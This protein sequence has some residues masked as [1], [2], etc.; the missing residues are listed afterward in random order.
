[1]G[2]IAVGGPLSMVGSMR[3]MAGPSPDT[4][5]VLVALSLHNRGLTFR[6]DGNEF[7]AEYR[8]ELAFRRGTE[9]IRQV[10]RD[11][12]IR[13]SSFRETL[14]TEESVIF[15]Q[16]VPVRAGDY[17]V[18]VV[19]R[20]RNGPNSARSQ[21]TL[22][23]PGL[24]PPAVSAAVAVYEATPRT[25]LAAPPTLIANPRNAVAYGKDS[26]KFYIE[27]YG[28]PAGSIL[29]VEATDPG[30]RTVFQDTL[31]PDAA[32]AVDGRVIVVPPGR[33][34]IGRHELRVTT[35]SGG[36]LA[37]VPFLVAFSDLWAIANFEDMISLL[38]YLPPADT[39]RTLSS[40]SPEERA[41]GWQAFWRAS[42]PNP[43]TPENEALDR[44]FAR[45]QLANE[46]FRDEGVP[47]WL[48]ERGEVFIT[49]G[50]PTNIIDQNPE[51]QG[52]GRV[53]YWTYDEYR[54]QLAFVDETGF[55]RMRLT[56]RSRAEYLVVVNRLRRQ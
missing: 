7:A 23:V 9:M 25:T 55:G 22:G 27:A 26:V 34:S 32:R 38:R 45:V 29:T 54:L 53:M 12:R 14:R 33:F 37:T 18:D 3:L 24:A 41:A 28:L 13:V 50:E 56:P 6:R 8:V 36:N 44:Y 10:V 19:V 40:A 5:L 16:V 21:V 30:G 17:V 49:I 47:G 4:T 11:E 51:V 2:L 42:D 1:M 48:T 39:L 35:A 20:D 52:R 43:A 15:Q 31:Q 46:R